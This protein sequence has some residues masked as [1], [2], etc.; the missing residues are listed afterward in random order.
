MTESA[1]QPLEPSPSPYTAGCYPVPIRFLYGTAAEIN[2]WDVVYFRSYTEGGV[3]ETSTQEMAEQTGLTRQ[4][5]S[6]LR[7]VALEHGE[8]AEDVSFTSGHR[9]NVRIP[10][11]DQ[12]RRGIIWKPLGYVANGWQ[13][14]V[15]PAIPKRILNLYLQQPRQRIYRLDAQYVAS[16]CQ[17]RFLYEPQPSIGPLN[18]ADVSNALRLLIQL[19]LLVPEENGVRLAWSTFTQP[20]AAAPARFAPTDPREHS[21][22]AESYAID[23]ARAERALELVLVGNYDLD[24]HFAD[25]FRDLAYIHQ[26]GD[27]HLLRKKVHTRRN[28][29]PGSNRWQET[30]R[31]F[32]SELKR[33]AAEIRFPKI[34]VPLDRAAPSTAALAVDLDRVPQAVT[35]VTAIA[36]LEGPWYLRDLPPVRLDILSLDRPL[37][38]RTLGIGYG[39]VR[40]NLRPDQWASTLVQLGLRATCEQPLPGM[41]IE[42]WVE[43]KLQR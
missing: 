29:P 4:M 16:K 31:V 33:H 10:N 5:I 40:F 12:L 39:E 43:A 17:R 21:V 32:H 2:F 38:T 27:Y 14:V 41:H 26:E 37:F 3:F 19:G 28:R 8:L 24:A 15:T 23:P 35:A 30:W 25:I 11:F 42:A 7:Q 6:R 9:F 22:F 1:H 34:V 18:A 13:R 20:P 36:R